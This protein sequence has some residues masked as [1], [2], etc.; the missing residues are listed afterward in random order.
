M[1]A[2]SFK[3]VFCLFQSDLRKHVA[4]PQSEVSHRKGNESQVGFLADY[5]ESICAK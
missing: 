5:Y 2:I 3:L 4:S 1:A